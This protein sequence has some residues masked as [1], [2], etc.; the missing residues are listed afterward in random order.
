MLRALRVI[1]AATPVLL[2][3]AQEPGPKAKLTARE[4]FFADRDEKAAR[5]AGTNNAGQAGTRKGRKPV[6]T[7][8]TS[9]EAANDQKAVP[10]ASSAPP[11]EESPAPEPVRSGSSNIVQ[12]AHAAVAPLGLRYS[13]LKIVDGEGIET[14]PDTTFRSGDR[15]QVKVEANDNG[16]LYIVHQGSSGKWNVMFPSP[17]IENGNNRVEKH[18]S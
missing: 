16:Y 4:M 17:N 2:L 11:A 10:V 8:A 1:C 14:P 3:C 15:I 9:P 18:R 7:K 6:G 13:V 5:P 12:A